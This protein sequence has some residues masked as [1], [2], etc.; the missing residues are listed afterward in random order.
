VHSFPLHIG[1]FEADAG[2][3][4]MLEDGAYNRLLRRYYR[5]GEPLPP[6][7]DQVARLARARSPEERDAVAAVLAEFFHLTP[8]GYVNRKAE[9]ILAAHAEACERNRTNGAKGGRPRKLRETETEPNGNPP[10]SGSDTERDA[11]GN[12]VGSVSLSQ[13]EPFLLP[14]SASLSPSEVEGGG[15]APALALEAQEQPAPAA[16]LSTLAGPAS[17]SAEQVERWRLAFPAVNVAAALLR[18][19]AWLDDNPQRRP[20]SAATLPRFVNGWL[21]RDQDRAAAQA[22]AQGAARAPGFAGRVI[23]GSFG[24]KAEAREER[25]ANVAQAWAGGVP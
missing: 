7:F 17:I 2:H 5:T 25:N 24:N 12:P 19:G 22:A 8:A 20:K 16:V 3:L 4:S 1:D 23:S 13:T 11:S 21:S 18:I 14:L 10:G 15:D 9:E 6:D